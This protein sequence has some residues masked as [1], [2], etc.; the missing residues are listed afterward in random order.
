MR[1][2]L[3]IGLML[4]SRVVPLRI[5]PAIVSSAA[6]RNA[7]TMFELVSVTKSISPRCNFA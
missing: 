3:V 7:R 5:C 2:G 6:A 4:T 1:T